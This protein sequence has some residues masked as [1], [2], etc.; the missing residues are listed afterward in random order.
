VSS[1]AKTSAGLL[2]FRFGD[3][4]LEVLLAHMGGPFWAAKDDGA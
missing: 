4:S 3:G 2:P 1:K